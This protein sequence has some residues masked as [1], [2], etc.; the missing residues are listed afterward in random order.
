MKKPELK[1]W[2][3]VEHDPIDSWVPDDPSLVD[4]WCN[5]SIGVSGEEGADNF[6]VRIVTQRLV[7][8]LRD[9]DHVLVISYYEGWQ[10]VLE[11]INA[12]IAGCKDISWSGISAQLSGVFKWEYDGFK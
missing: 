9:Y 4:I 7:S 1:S 6:E 8:Q 11:L 3:C 12:K 2:D 5:L 10:Q